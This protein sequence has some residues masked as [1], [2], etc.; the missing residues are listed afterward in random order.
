MTAGYYCVSMFCSHQ[1]LYI[2]GDFVRL[3]FCENFYYI[4]FQDEILCS[5]LL[6]QTVLPGILEQVVSCKDAIAQEYLME[7]IIQVCRFQTRWFIVFVS[8]LADCLFFVYCLVAL[9]FYLFCISS[10]TVLQ[11]FPDEFHLKT[12]STFLRACA[13]LHNSVNIKNILIAVI[14][15]FVI[16]PSTQIL[17]VG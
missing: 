13:E 9:V 8:F 1:L 3:V 14:D 11:V 2:L 15:R 6:L 16:L 7:C 17:L 5:V 12:L 4:L 10:E